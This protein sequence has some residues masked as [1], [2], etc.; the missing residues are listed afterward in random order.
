MFYDPE[1]CSFY[2]EKGRNATPAEGINNSI[3]L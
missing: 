1:N 3:Y 2:L